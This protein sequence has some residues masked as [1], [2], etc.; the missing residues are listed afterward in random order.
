MSLDNK[1]IHGADEVLKRLEEAK[2]Y[3][4]QDVYEAIGI[5][6]VR[7]FKMA[8]TDEGFTDK[9]LTKWSA[10]KTKTKL[11][12]NILTGQGSGDHL[13]D[14]IDYKTT[15]PTV[16]IFTDKEYAQIHN[17]GG[18][19]TVTTQMK[20]FFWAKH[21]EAKDGGDSEMA[22]QYKYMALAKKITIPKRQ[23]IGNSETMMN[24]ISEKVQRD[25]NKIL[26]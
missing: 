25:L 16:T 2:Q 15:P 11:Q 10:R 23:F 22:E 3:L 21:K 19:I 26:N 8:F 13:A 4:Q 6:A 12:R 14:S 18:E 5:E 17:E 7:H 24:K 1:N 9:N 20:K